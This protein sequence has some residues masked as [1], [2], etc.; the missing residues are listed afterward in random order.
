MMSNNRHRTCCFYQGLGPEDN[1]IILLT[2]LLSIH[3]G[4][5]LS[6]GGGGGT[7]IFSA[8]IGSDPASTVHRQK[9]KEFQAPPEIFEI[10]ATQ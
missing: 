9:Y 7:L 2:T 5:G 6:P 8:Y 10:L 1:L 4:N 3:S